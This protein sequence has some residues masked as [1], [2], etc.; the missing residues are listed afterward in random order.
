[1]T[2]IIVN[3]DI[4]HSSATGRP[5]TVEGHEKFRQDVREN[6]EIEA[7][8]NGTG[9]DLQNVI[10][11]IGDVF[12]LRME[13]TRRISTAFDAYRAAQDQIQKFDRT[14]NERFSRVAQVVCSPVRDTQTGLLSS[15]TYA[16]RV[17]VLSRNPRAGA[18]TLSGTLVR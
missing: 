1:M 4:Q 3:G 14:E 11:L 16:F 7:Q 2:F 17:D 15:T 9:A 6:L 8:P 5:L 13:I 10:S 12:S 18:A